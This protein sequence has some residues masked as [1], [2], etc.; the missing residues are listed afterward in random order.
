MPLIPPPPPFTHSFVSWGICDF[1]Y[2]LLLSY[3]LA[4]TFKQRSLRGCPSVLNQHQHSCLNDRVGPQSFFPDVVRSNIDFCVLSDDIK[5]PMPDALVCCASVSLVLVLSKVMTTMW[6][7][8]SRLCACYR[9][10]RSTHW[11][12]CGFTERKCNYT[13]VMPSMINDVG[14]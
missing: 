4:N 10:R 11:K 13:A 3:V 5:L 14:P 2:C 8:T 1:S 6:L 9:Q 12:C 7:T